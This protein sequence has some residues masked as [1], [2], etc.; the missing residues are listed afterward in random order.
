MTPK[1]KVFLLNLLDIARWMTIVLTIISIVFSL[2]DYSI[3]IAGCS[4]LLVAVSAIFFARVSKFAKEIDRFRQW[5]R[6]VKRPIEHYPQTPEQVLLARKE[7]YPV[8]RGLAMDVNYATERLDEARMRGAPNEVRA[9]LDSLRTR[10]RIDF[11]I[12]W[13]VLAYVGALPINL[14]T[15]RM[16]EEKDQDAFLESISH[17]ESVFHSHIGEYA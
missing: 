15:G 10:M 8:L 16:W 4:V 1:K 2:I 3:F 7:L 13:K 14:T 17:E 11:L 12:Y 5:E 6:I 9:D